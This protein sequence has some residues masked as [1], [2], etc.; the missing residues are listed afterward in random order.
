MLVE[1]KDD[2]PI[3]SVVSKF[4][5]SDEAFFDRVEDFVKNHKAHIKGVKRIEDDEDGKLQE[6]LDKLSEKYEVPLNAV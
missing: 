6:L 1:F 4:V 2:C 5:E 3:P